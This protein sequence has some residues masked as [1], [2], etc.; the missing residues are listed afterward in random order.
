[1]TGVVD[2]EE[3]RAAAAEPRYRLLLALED[4]RQ[5]LLRLIDDA[6][7]SLRLA[8]Y[9]FAADEIGHAVRDALLAALDRGVSVSLLIDGFGSGTTPDSFFQP[10]VEAGAAFCRFHPRYGRRYFFRNHQKLIVA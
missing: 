8:Y 6:R 5:A 3:E 9:I 10:L 7:L 4:R 1:M 2:R